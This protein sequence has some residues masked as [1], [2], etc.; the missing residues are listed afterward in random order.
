MDLAHRPLESHERFMLAS[1]LSALNPIPT[2]RAFK[3]LGVQ[4]KLTNL[5]YGESSKHM[6]GAV[7]LQFC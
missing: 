1:V 6:G 4:A 7:T 2:L 5:V 3:S